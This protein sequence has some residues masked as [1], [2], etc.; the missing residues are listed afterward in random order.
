ML[1]LKIFSFLLNR[2]YCWIL[3]FPCKEVLI[4][5]GP[6]VHAIFFSP[7]I[8]VVL[9]AVVIYILQRFRSKFSRGPQEYQ[10]K[11]RQPSC[12]FSQACSS[13][14]WQI[15]EWLAA[16]SSIFI[17][18]PSKEGHKD[19][20]PLYLFLYSSPALFFQPDFSQAETIWNLKLI[21]QETSSHTLWCPDTAYFFTL[22]VGLFSQTR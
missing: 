7:F 16:L 17:L 12:R 22:H 20:P 5:K 11:A 15:F 21:W 13:L 3:C 9:I 2:T 14:R 18:W 1:P 19:F 10:E 6:C 4:C 8:L